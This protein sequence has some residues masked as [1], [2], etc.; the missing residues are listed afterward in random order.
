MFRQLFKP[1][2]EAENTGKTLLTIE[3]L[4][5]Q[6]QYSTSEY[7]PS[8]HGQGQISLII[9]TPNQVTGLVISKSLGKEKIVTNQL[10]P[11]IADGY[12][13]HGGLSSVIKLVR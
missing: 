7:L 3:A 6:Q 9:L 12:A 2:S 1:S 4:D 13:D 8:V 5:P 11:M 10:K